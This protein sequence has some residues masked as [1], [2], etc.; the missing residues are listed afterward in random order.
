MKKR[1][2]RRYILYQFLIPAF[3]IGTSFKA[4]LRAEIGRIRALA[5]GFA[6]DPDRLLFNQL[7]V[8]W[9]IG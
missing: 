7:R 8:N 1:S 5:V 3:L 9:P 2:T 4:L 6:M